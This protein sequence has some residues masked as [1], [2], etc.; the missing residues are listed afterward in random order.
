MSF[1]GHQQKGGP[2]KLFSSN[3]Q[4]FGKKK[5]KSETLYYI[6]LMLHNNRVCLIPDVDQLFMGQSIEGTKNIFVSDDSRSY[7]SSL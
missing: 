6:S 1:D 7:C 3:I 4:K 2:S 5:N